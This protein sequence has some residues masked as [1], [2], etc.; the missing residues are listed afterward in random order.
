MSRVRIPFSPRVSG[1]LVVVAATA[2]A[3][4]GLTQCKMVPS[5]ITGVE[6]AS[7]E[8]GARSDCVQ[9]CNE[10]F[11]DARETERDRHFHAL[12]L[13]GRDQ[14]CKRAERERHDAILEALVERMR[15]CKKGCYNE[16][17]GTGGKGDR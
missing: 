8:F 5:T 4:T 17:G 16:G 14:A 13:C 3:I 1:W 6:F 12:L 2:L 15:D 11:K 7:N 9:Q 10:D